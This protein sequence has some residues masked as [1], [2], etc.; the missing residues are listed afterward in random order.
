MSAIIISL[1]I[2]VIS[3]AI[4]FVL[5]CAAAR[6]VLNLNRSRDVVD[7]ILTAPMVLPPT[8]VGFILLLIFGK[9]G[10]VGALLAKIGAS[11]VFTQTG[12]VIAAAVVSFPLVYRTARGSFEQMDENLIFAARTLGMS[13]T[14][15]FF[16]VTFPN[17]R[18]G[19]FSGA[20]LAFARALGEFGATSMIAGNIPGRTQTM[21]LAIYSAVAGNNREKAY[22][23]VAIIMAISFFCIFLMNFLAQRG[24][25]VSRR[26]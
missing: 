23:W 16:S 20:V 1:K 22:F 3:T 13:E 7:G 2:A 12:A 11:V 6:L 14:R 8:V 10:A 5:G 18:A 4:T 24:F 15:I 21:S 9:N 17:C 26:Y 25:N 19:V